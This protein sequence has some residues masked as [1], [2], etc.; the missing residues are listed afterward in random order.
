[1]DKSPGDILVYLQRLPVTT[2]R[3]T[4]KSMTE[5]LRFNLKNG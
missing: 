5:W 2:L 3:C 1:M 4:I